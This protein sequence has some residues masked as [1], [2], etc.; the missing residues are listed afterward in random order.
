MIMD[1]LDTLSHVAL[2][3]QFNLGLSFE[4]YNPPSQG[5]SGLRG[6]VMLDDSDN[7]NTPVTTSCSDSTTFSFSTDV[8]SDMPEPLP[9]T[10]KFT[11]LFSPLPAQAE[12]R[13]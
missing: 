6:S 7:L 10:G 5:N 9:I 13:P 4:T 11:F 3:D 8:M 2:A 1:G 12:R